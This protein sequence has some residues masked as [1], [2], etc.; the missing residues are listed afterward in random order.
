MHKRIMTAAVAATVCLLLAG[1]ASDKT[2]DLSYKQAS[3]LPPLEVPPELSAPDTQG[4][5]MPVPEGPTSAQ[6]A[7]AGAGQ[8]AAATGAAVQLLPQPGNVR[9]MH[10]G[11]MSW[12]VV[13][14]TPEKLWPRLLAFWKQ[15]GLKVKREDPATGIMETQWAVN[16]AELPQDFISRTFSKIFSGALGGA[17]RDKYHLRLERGTAPGTTELYLT[18]YK[19]AEV[20]TGSTDGFNQT[21]WQNRSG[22]PAQVNEM[23]ARMLVFLGESQKQAQALVSQTTPPA[24]RA[25]LEVGSDGVPAVVVTEDFAHAWRRVGLALD[26]LG[27]VV[28][29]QDRAKGDYFVHPTDLAADANGSSGKGFFSS[30]FSGKGESQKLALTRIRVVDG[31]ATTRVTVLGADGQP[32]RSD[33]AKALLT[34]LTAALR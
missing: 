5:E 32:D 6:Q 28:D 1:C 27:L 22:D 24:A 3:T 17:T 25:R 31:G 7:S 13:Q 10:D 2:S 12:L 21:Q 33:R 34:K 11:A 19:L 29:R 14:A 8:Q 16:Q 23:L 20:V 26:Q 18:Q 9:V 4:S 30:M 15:Q